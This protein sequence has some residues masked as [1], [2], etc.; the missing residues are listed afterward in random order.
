MVRYAALRFAEDEN[1]ADRVYWYRCPFPAAA[2]EKV[3]APV[4]A[5]DRLQRAEVVRVRTDGKCPCEE[6]LLKTVAAR[7]GAF[8]R[9]IGDTVVFE[10]GGLAY[11]AKHFTRYGQVLFGTWEGAARGV[12]PIAAVEEFSALYAVLRTQDCVLLTGPCARRAA[13]DLLLLAGVAAADISAR[14]AAC[15]AKTGQTFPEQWVRAE[16]TRLEAALGAQEA[17]RLADRL[18]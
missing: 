7:C 15:G 2:G 12:T 1:I 11:D 9:R 4:G 16:R 13:A 10:T 14:L 17:A 6:R 5:H 8:R 3:F 18:R